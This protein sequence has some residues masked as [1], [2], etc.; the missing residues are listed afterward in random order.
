[1]LK[2]R[3]KF[4]FRK[5]VYLCIQK[6][7]QMTDWKKKAMDYSRENKVLNKRIKELTHSRDGWKQKSAGHKKRADD[8][9]AEKKKSKTD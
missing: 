2:N 8:L 4:A 1:M 6:D 9:E 3:K 7:T 5:F